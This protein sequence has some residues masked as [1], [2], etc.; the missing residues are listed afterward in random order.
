MKFS[1]LIPALLISG[2]CLAQEKHI[3]LD[4]VVVVAQ[5]KDNR[6]GV[7]VRKTE[8]E[9]TEI[10]R[11]AT[12][13][14]SELLQEG[15]SLQIKSM[16]QGAQ[17]TV[18]FRGT[19]SSHT[20][21]LWNGISINSPQL[22]C[23]DF[24]QVPV[25]FIDQVTLTHGSA[26]P[27]ATAGA[28]GGTINFSGEN[29]PI[30]GF[31]LNLISEIASN[32]TYTQAA[33]FKFT[34]GKLTATTRAFYQQSE[35]NYKY[36][37][38]VY[39]SEHTIERRKEADYKQGGILQELTYRFSEKNK[40]VWNGWLQ[41]DDRSLPQ[42]VIVNV[43]AAE[44]SKSTNYRTSMSYDHHAGKNSFMATVGY[45]RG[46]MDYKRK[47]GEFDTDHSVNIYNSLTG[48]AEYKY[49][50]WEKLIPTALIHYRFDNVNS[51]NYNDKYASR[52][53]YSAKML[54]TC[55]P[56]PKLQID[57]GG[58]FQGTDER[59]FGTYSVSGRYQIIPRLL[60]VKLSHSY[61]HRTPTLNDLYWNPGGNPELKDETSFG[62][63]MTLSSQADI[64]R[65]TLSAEATYYDMLVDNW[66][67]WIPKGNGY[68]W[69]PVN[70]SK[71]RSRGTE[72][73]FKVGF[74]L[75]NLKQTATAAYT[76]AAST[77]DSAREDGTEGKQ[78]PYV[79]RNRWS[80]GYRLDYRNSLW[81]HYNT[82]YTGVRFTSADESYQTNAYTLH[83]FEVGYLFRFAKKYSLGLSCKL[84]NAFNAYYEST[85]YYPMPLRMFWGRLTFNM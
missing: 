69:E 75:H 44:Q 34:A 11:N 85:Q 26:T 31:R 46:E 39:S 81:F 73:N 36:L 8:V 56:L 74:R 37:N 57:G 7:G 66:I 76:Y 43:T 83:N 55:Y 42:S 24:S 38:K 21:V 70:F 47:F 51:D 9:K 53:N 30:K 27:F 32:E 48:T 54:L 19:S 82:S 77:D 49:S 63:D 67:M 28:L 71:V 22:G 1:L 52:H 58:T 6:G 12:R 41:M 25:Y 64:D 5:K 60:E 13:S 3:R 16:G 80:A 18:S 45:L 61:N 17:A 10:S 79:P 50:G 78:L 29:A 68:I 65:V 59:I 40:L 14:L 72:L 35:N 23:F 84:E 2:L 4:S 33:T 62:W 15:T 20:Q